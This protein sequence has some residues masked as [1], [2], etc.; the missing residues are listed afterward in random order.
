MERGALLMSRFKRNE[1]YTLEGQNADA[2]IEVV[3][4]DEA[5]EYIVEKHSIHKPPPFDRISFDFRLAIKRV[6]GAPIRCWRL[7][8]YI[9]ND[10]A[11]ADREAVEIYPPESKVTNEANMYHLWVYKE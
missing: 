3:L 5:G 11:G 2:T 1:I 6:D 9:K 8:Q 7:L 10:V 4:T